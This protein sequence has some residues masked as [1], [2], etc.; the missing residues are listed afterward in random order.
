MR[1]RALFRTGFR[2]AAGSCLAQLAADVAGVQAPWLRWA[3]ALLFTAGAVDMG[4][5]LAHAR[6]TAG[7]RAGTGPA[8]APGA[9]E[10]QRGW[11]DFALVLGAQEKRLVPPPSPSR[12]WAGV[13][14]PGSPVYSW[15]DRLGRLQP[16]F[17]VHYRTLPPEVLTEGALAGDGVMEAHSDPHDGC[18]ACEAWRA[19]VGR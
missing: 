18:P 5:A 12:Q 10:M 15:H 11:D 7:G 6:L 1:L 3:V 13:E 16:P 2:L 9:R 4:I 17:P 8:R 14:F 19:R